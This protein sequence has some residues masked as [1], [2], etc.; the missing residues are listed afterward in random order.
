MIKHRNKCVICQHPILV[1]CYTFKEFPIYMGT[2]PVNEY[3]YQDMEWVSCDKC[4]EIQLKTLIDES[5]LC[6]ENCFLSITNSCR[7]LP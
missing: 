6:K 7:Q 2:D 4:G 3:H 1:D 5:V